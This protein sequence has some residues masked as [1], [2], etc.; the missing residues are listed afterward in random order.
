[1]FSIGSAAGLLMVL[2]IT[3]RSAVLLAHHY[4][5]LEQ[6]EQEASRPDLALRGVRERFLPVAT[7]T[8]VTTVGLLPLVVSGGAPGLEIVHPMAV[9]MVGGLITSTLL[10]LFALPALYSALRTRNEPEALPEPE[11][12]ADRRVHHAAE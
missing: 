2:L 4:Q 5:R 11:Y 6:D 3:A 10:V 8:V 9:V 1:V 7:T 12:E